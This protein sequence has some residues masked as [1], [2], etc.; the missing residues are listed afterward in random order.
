MEFNSGFK[1]LNS[2]LSEGEWSATGHC[3]FGCGENV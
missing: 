1:G 2:E 3:L